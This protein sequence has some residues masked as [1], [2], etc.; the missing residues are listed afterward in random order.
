L[1]VTC[2]T[3]HVKIV[4]RIRAMENRDRKVAE[5]LGN[6]NILSKISYPTISEGQGGG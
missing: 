5:I 4:D 2:E 3:K 1:G 6:R